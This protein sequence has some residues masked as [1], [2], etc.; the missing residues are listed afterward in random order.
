VWVTSTGAG[1]S[2]DSLIAYLVPG[3]PFYELE[4]VEQDLGG[5]IAPGVTEAIEETILRF[6][7]SI[8]IFRFRVPCSPLESSQSGARSKQAMWWRRRDSNLI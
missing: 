7:P 5:F 3:Q 2:E 1:T 8:L 4:Q 6:P